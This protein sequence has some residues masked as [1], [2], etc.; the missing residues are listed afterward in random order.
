[1]DVLERLKKDWK[2]QSNF[3]KVTKDDIYAL[4]HKTSSSI[5]KWIFIL[6]L[7]EFGFWTI[8]GF[9]IKDNEAQQR[10]NAYEM[11]HITTPLIV[12]GYIILA[13]F[14]IL[15]YNNYRKISAADSVKILMQ[16]ILVTRKTVKH[17]VIFNLVFLYISIFVG[18]W[19]EITKNPEVK[20]VVTQ[21]NENGNLFIFYGTIAIIT[22]VIMVVST[23]LLLGFY[24]LVYGFLL[25]RLKQNY[26][27]LHSISSLENQD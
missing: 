18:L 16:K 4:L 19:I 20:I 2:K 25:K 6:S 17:Y 9:F 24:Y 1:M 22:I 8:I 3:P 13:Y 26:K 11:E 27:E 23:A 21:S 15:F 5:V 7:I 12:V 10:F 14:F